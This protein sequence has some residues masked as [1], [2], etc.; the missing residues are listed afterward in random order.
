MLETDVNA[1]K[2]GGQEAPAL[3]TPEYD[4][5]MAQK[6]QDS[7]DPSKIA[8]NPVDPAVANQM[9]EGGHEKFWDA[10]KGVYNW[11]AHATELQFKIDQK[12]PKEERQDTPDEANGE[13]KAV[14]NIIEK[15]GLNEDALLSE[16]TANGKLSDEQVAALK[17]V[18]IPESIIESHVEGVKARLD[19][20]RDSMVAH[21]GGAEAYNQMVNW[22]NENLSDEGRDAVNT[23][24]TQGNWKS[25]LTI[26][27]NEYTQ[28]A[29]GARQGTLLAGDGSVTG[30]TTIYESKA[31]QSA[32]IN[33]PKYRT[34]PAFRAQV[35]RR[36]AATKNAGG[37]KH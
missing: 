25:A 32:D 20:V 19:G 30:D 21:L 29:R 2:D 23:L 31:Q 35:A 14:G 16:I 15:A 7:K 26:I 37:F 3:G 10:D 27:Q 22:G 36:I 24:F 6:F 18:G 5:A 1:N 17:S 13:E 33:N 9:P 12:A 28:N 8:D 34:D 11:Q 4:A